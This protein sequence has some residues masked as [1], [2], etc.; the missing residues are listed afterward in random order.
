MQ[1]RNVVVV[2]VGGRPPKPTALKKLGGN[3]GKRA[4]NKSEPRPAHK[5]PSCPKHLTGEAKKEWNRTSK[6]LFE[7]GLLTEL[8]R[9]ALAAYCQAWAQWVQAQEEMRK[10][11]F[12]MIEVT[13]SGYPVASPWLNVAAQAMK[14][15]KTFLT[16][17][18]MTPSSRSRV[19]VVT[20]PEAD[21]YEAYL[22]GEA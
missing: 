8:D 17:F 5:R 7:L 3:A 2:G 19:T 14:Q 1:P 13:E 22:K 20:E 16:E 21:P 10:P 4:I 9:A 12:K 18:G 6:Q 15:M 11:T